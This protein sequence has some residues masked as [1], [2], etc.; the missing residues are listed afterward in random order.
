MVFD[1][2]QFVLTSYLAA[3][4][5]AWIQENRKDGCKMIHTKFNVGLATYCQLAK[6]MIIDESHNTF[7]AHR[8]P[9]IEVGTPTL[10]Y[11]PLQPHWIAR[12]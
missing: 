11:P 6:H 2:H 1:S 10:I 8:Q 3:C 7:H 9:L 5:W 12:Y 4:L